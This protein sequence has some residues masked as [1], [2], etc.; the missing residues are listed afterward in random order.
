VI[1]RS[2]EVYCDESHPELFVSPRTDAVRAV[3]GSLWI[4][5]DFRASLKKDVAGLRE[6]HQVWGE[7]KWK[8]ISPS[9]EAFYLDLVDYFFG[10]PELQFRAIV[11][12]SSKLNLER[13]HSADAEL[14]FYKFYYQL[15]HHWI[16]APN[17]YTVFCDDK[18]N[19]DPRRVLELGKVLANA[20]RGA[21]VAPLR[22]VSSS[23]SAGVQFCDILLGATQWCANGAPG[24]STSKAAVVSRIEER[25]GHA[26]APT[27][28]SERKFNIFNIRLRSDAA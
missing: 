10:R 2:F 16:F 28:P 19:R 14:G 9:R 6:T 13:Y 4:P 23:Q 27:Q 18:V 20:N 24:T 7:F 11:I 8:K 21:I 17:R 15:V 25:L 1:A 22:S 5:A 26:I 3:I 12:D